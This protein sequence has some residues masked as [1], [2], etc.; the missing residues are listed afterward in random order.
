MIEL[1]RAVAVAMAD[2]PARGLEIVDAIER[3]G[4]LDGYHLLHSARGELLRQLGRGAEAADSYR[5]AL[6]LTTNAVER[7]HLQRRL[8]L[9]EAAPEG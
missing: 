9:V 2:G 6:E 5:T 1:N 7:R 3:D 4:R 8:A